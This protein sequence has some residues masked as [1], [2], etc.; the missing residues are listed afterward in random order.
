MS[1]WVVAGLLALGCSDIALA[2]DAGEDRHERTPTDLI[3]TAPYTRDR[4]AVLSGTSVLTDE[5]LTRQMRLTIGETLARQPGVSST[6]FGPNASRPVL[7]GLQ[8]E[9][10][11]VL[12]DGIGSIDVSNTSVDHAVVVNPLSAQR[13]EVLRGPAALLYG[14]SAIGGVV[15]VI[16]KRIPRVVPDEAVHLD[17]I[18]NY[19][20]AAN[21]RSGYG[22]LDV[23]IGKGFV[24][25]LDGSYA[26][27][28]DLDTG[29]FILTPALRAQAAASGIPEIEELATLEGKLPNSAARTWEVAAGAA[30]IADGGTLGISFSRYDSLYGVPIRYSL[31]PDIEAEAV[32][33]QVNQDRVD[34]RGE[35]KVGGFIDPI[36]L[37][38]G[39]ADYIHAEI[40]D[41]GEIGTTFFNKSIEAR[42]EVTQAQRG[43]WRGAFGGQLMVRDFNVIGEEAFVPKNSTRQYGLFTLQELDFGA[44]KAEGGA[45]FERTLLKATENPIIGNPDFTRNFSAFSGSLGGSFAVAEGI[46]I[47]LLGSYT[48]RAPSAEELFA[49]GPHKGTQA[50]EVGNPD[51]KKERAKGIEVSLRGARDGLSFSLSAYHNW[52]DDYIYEVQT[53]AASPATDDLPLFEF[54]QNDARYWGIEGEA[55]LRLAQ[56]GGFALSI[57][58]L[59]DYTRGTIDSGGPV[60]R[61][62]PLRLLGGIE[63]QSDRLNL[64]AEVEWSASQRRIAAF[65]TETEGFTLVNASIAFHPLGRDNATSITLS[66]NNIFDVEARRHASFLKDYAPLAGRDIRITGRIAF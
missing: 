32:R 56:F 63:G 61:V 23:P 36:K 39:F 60:P 1:K 25:H 33:L 3:V 34:L 24:V 9:R 46:R 22:H 51:F 62:P 27:T 41:T 57:D 10:V 53:A 58:A 54:F 47:G 14:S 28:D 17:G 43:A 2:E 30:Y 37:R 31:D 29:S 45:R 50:F 26:K 52:F 42:L 7:R 6:A 48:E 16:D 35:V 21:E 4:A 38:V 65:E 18:A 20:S 40:E 19:G 55:S 49:N 5:V 15:N 11:R 8:G 13:I 44:F 12:K 59:G 64:R 66:A